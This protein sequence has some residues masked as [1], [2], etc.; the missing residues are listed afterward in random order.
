MQ[1]R[2]FGLIAALT[3]GCAHMA[4]KVTPD[5]T[6]GGVPFLPIESFEVVKLSYQQTWIELRV[7]GVFKRAGGGGP[8]TPPSAG[9][10]GPAGHKAVDVNGASE[11][12]LAAIPDLKPFAKKI[13][14]SRPYAGLADLAAKHVLT[15]PLLQKV[16]KRLT[17]GK[18]SP[19]GDDNGTFT[20]TVIAHTRDLES[21]PGDADV[22][23]AIYAAFIRETDGEKSWNLSAGEIL[24][25]IDGK[26]LSF[27]D[28]P[29]LPADALPG[30]LK[31]VAQERLRTQAPAARPLYLNI[32]V[33]SGGSVSGEV[34][35]APNG[36][37]TKASS[38]VQDLLPGAV[39]SAGGSVLSAALGSSAL[40]TVAAHF[41]APAVAPA[42]QAVGSPTVQKV[43]LTL[44]WNRRLYT[45]TVTRPAGTSESS[46]GAL[47]SMLKFPAQPGPPPAQ[48]AAAPADTCR[49]SVSVETRRGGDADQAKPAKDDG[50]AKSHGSSAPSKSAGADTKDEH[51]GTP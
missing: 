9:A 5:G 10:P 34:D 31:L 21:T 35:L 42:P 27:A 33:P 11:A 7:D 38:Q 29:L 46:C 36:T 3:C 32:R 37:M 8:G 20:R 19:G 47:A 4:Y 49:A 1:L 12:E 30:T 39:V 26:T 2:S 18:Q 44:T 24:S 50:G 41:F 40:N 17:A 23:S 22:A 6:C 25:K 14:A 28:P 13:V 43:D 16:S 48:P 15:E 45:V 51:D